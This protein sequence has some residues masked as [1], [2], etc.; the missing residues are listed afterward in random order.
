MHSPREGVTTSRII[1]LC[2]LVP[3]ITPACCSG[4]SGYDRRRGDVVSFSFPSFA[5]V[6]KGDRPFDLSWDAGIVD[7][8]LHLTVDDANQPLVRYPP[9]PRRQ[10]GRIILRPSFLLSVASSSSR[11]PSQDASFNT[12]FTMSVSRRLSSNQ[13]M[14]ATKTKSKSDGDGGG[15]GLL[16]QLLPDIMAEFSRVR[17]YSYRYNGYYRSSDSL[18][19]DNTYSSLA[20]LTTS[21]NISVDMGSTRTTYEGYNGLY[22]LFTPATPA[23][24]TVWIDY[25][26]TSQIIWVYVGE[27]SKPKPAQATLGALNISGIFRW[28]D[29]GSYFGLMASND[30]SNSLPS[31][32]PVI[33]SWNLTVDKLYK[34]GRFHMAPWFLA[35][36][37][38]SGL[39]ATIAAILVLFRKIIARALASRYRALRMKLRLSRALRR[40]PGIPREFKYADVKKATKNFHQSL[41]LGKGGF[42]AVYK[43]TI[44]ITTTDGDGEEDDGQRHRRPADVAVKKFTRKDNRGYQDFLAE[45]AV[46]NRLR[47]KN[48]VPLTGWCYESGKLLLLYQYMPNGSLDQHLF[49]KDR[50]QHFPT[51]QWEKRYSVIRDVAA[52]LHYAHHEYER[53]VL[54]RDIKASNILLDDA[55][56]GRLGDFGLAR[57]VGFNKNS[58][59]DMGIAGTWGFIAP[60]YAV[61]HRATRQT[62]V[63][64]FGVLVLEIV[65]GRRSLSAADAPFPLLTDW[66]WWLHRE[67]RLL[68]A[69]DDVLIADAFDADEVTRMLL[70]GLACS[71]PKASDRPSMAEAVQVVAKSMPPPPV[72]MAKPTFL[73]PPEGELQLLMEDADDD[74]VGSMGYDDSEWSHR[75]E[76]RTHGRGFVISIGSLEIT[77]GRS[78]KAR[79]L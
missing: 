64:A 28:P 79:T 57:V 62:D 58:I 63:Y 38:C 67:G 53:V 51:L 74:L 2:C 32:Q 20:S 40:L 29:Y 37:L 71:N 23:N 3:I 12:S 4:V 70:L 33:Y 77:V 35:I 69:V 68:E 7:G 8:A 34:P 31:C 44:Q 46:I 52:G 66:V 5:H 45:V 1:L 41:L 22:V 49:H 75:E 39:V 6:D 54:H 73:W 78:G 9:D 26:G 18:S 55:F 27:G 65:T 11:N 56:R 13:D 76:A 30:G 16:F 24:Y 47:H 19:S 42:G 15:S 72:P 17:S 59:T 36:V 14:A 48:I 50:H 10:L 61:S 21:G 25:D 43:G 60:E